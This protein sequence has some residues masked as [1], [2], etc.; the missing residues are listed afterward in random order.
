MKL[1]M[2]PYGC[3][4]DYWRIRQFLRRVFLKNG[5]TEHSWNV[6]RLDY[7]RWHVAANC[8]ICPPVEEVIYMWEDGGGR[9][10]AVLNPEGMGE[11]H[12]QIDPEI[13]T[14]A[15]EE[16]MLELAQEK[17]PLVREGRKRLGLMVRADDG[18]R[19]DMLKALGY[20]KGSFREQHRALELTVPPAPVGI[21]NGWTI[22]HQR[23]E[24]VPARSW[25]SWK[26]FHPDDPDDQ[27]DGHEWY[28]NLERIPLYRRDLDVI[29]V[30][31][32]GRVGGF[33]TI[34]FD[35]ATRTGYMEPVGRSSDVEVRGLMRALLTEACRRLHA[36]GGNLVTV[37]GCDFAANALYHSVLGPCR[38]VSENWVREW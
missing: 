4:E 38:Q 8:G 24:D 37:G 17:F 33:C 28:A 19:Q 10:A 20:K 13:R 36:I 34:W 11:A 31:P 35:D 22:R 5:R 12:L 27:Y 21:P 15:L 23:P 14:A 3:E 32:D 2:R 1:R 6:A 18:M 29:A 7:W 30:E 16:E 25:A 9:L 26:A